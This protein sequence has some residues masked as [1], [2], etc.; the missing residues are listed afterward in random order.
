MKTLLTLCAFVVSIAAFAQNIFTVDN[1]PT[2]GAQYTSVQDAIDAASAGDFIYVQ[3]SPESYGNVTI[4]KT[5]HIR[6]LG[7]HPAISNGESAKIA[8]INLSAPDGA[9]E[10]SISGLE[11]AIIKYLG[12]V[13]ADYSGLQIINNKIT[14]Y[15]NS[16]ANFCDDW[17][18]QGNVFALSG[19]NVIDG[20]NHMNWVMVNNIF[21]NA[22]TDWTWNTFNNFNST[23]TFRNNVIL[24]QQNNSAT[25]WMFNNTTN[26][27]IENCI[28]IYGAPVAETIGGSNFTNPTFNNCLTYNLAGGTMTALS[29]SDNLDNTDPMFVSNTDSWFAYSDDFHL[30]NASPAAGYGTDGEDIGIFGNSIDFSMDGYPMDLPYPTEMYISTTSVNSGGV[31]EV[32]FKAKGN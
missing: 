13:N 24:S 27:T 21:V 18:L 31:L 10:S 11:V 9:P 25:V 6:G 5:I 1:N 22:A 15:I 2:A 12:S 28:F 14:N 26:L 8:Q 7:H 23:T 16:N 3:P 4:S 29:G 20:Q 19:Y 32:E 30:D 17:L